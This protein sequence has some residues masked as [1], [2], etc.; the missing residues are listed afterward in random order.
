MNDSPVKEFF[1]LRSWGELDDFGSLNDDKETTCLL[2]EYGQAKCWFFANGKDQI[3]NYL[4]VDRKYLFSKTSD[5]TTLCLQFTSGVLACNGPS[6]CD[7]N[8][9]SDAFL[10]SLYGRKYGDEISFS[11]V[12][13]F[14]SF[15]RSDNIRIR[16]KS[17]SE[18]WSSWT[19]TLL[20]ADNV[21]KY[22][23]NR[24][25][26]Q[27][28]SIQISGLD[29]NAFTL[30]TP[31]ELVNTS[32]FLPGSGKRL[33]RISESTFTVKPPLATMTFDTKRRYVKGFMQGAEM[34]YKVKFN[35]EYNGTCNIRVD[36]GDSYN[37]AGVKVYPP[38]SDLHT[39]FTLKVKNGTGQGTIIYR[40]NGRY[41]TEMTCQSP[42]YSQ[43]IA[44]KTGIFKASY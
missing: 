12:M 42:L 11:G 8:N 19:N 22:K 15:N 30:A 25:V 37:F 7:T 38:Y 14:C 9:L 2:E 29:Y 36:L 27:T 34:T 24:K 16:L 43:S 39:E 4:N 21:I 6:S 10:D 33:K 31:T 44:Y 23:P 3:A 18:K 1:G 32:N 5:Y 40:W 35:R 20:T 17:G 26:F 41:S 28:T 13:R